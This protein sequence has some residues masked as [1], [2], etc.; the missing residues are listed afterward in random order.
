MKDCTC[1]TKVLT[2]QRIEKFA[3][4]ARAYICTY[5]YI[6]QMLNK[7]N[8]ARVVAIDGENPTASSAARQQFL[9]SEVDRVMRNFKAHRCVLDFDTGFVNSELKEVKE[10]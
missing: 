3:S 7:E 9:F 4:R 6:E 5:H 2:K 10:E 8:A 1:P